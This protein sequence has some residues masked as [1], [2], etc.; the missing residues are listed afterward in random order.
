L[1]EL[2]PLDYWLD[3]WGDAMTE[4]IIS[5][6]SDKSYETILGLCAACCIVSLLLG[7]FGLI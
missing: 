6:L 5:E 3:Y 7:G 4:R 2:K 1:D